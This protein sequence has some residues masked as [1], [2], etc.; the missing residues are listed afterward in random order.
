M[1][2]HGEASVIFC[3]R[4]CLTTGFLNFLNQGLVSIREFLSGSGCGQ[5][6]EAQQKS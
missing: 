3:E 6:Q 2:C 5:Q 1:K 4:H